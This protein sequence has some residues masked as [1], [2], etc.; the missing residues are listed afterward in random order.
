MFLS[1]VL[2][3]DTALFICDMDDIDLLLT[4]VKVGRRGDED[5]DWRSLTTSPKYICS[6]FTVPANVSASKKV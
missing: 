2:D 5:V 6:L 4:F 1:F 3:L